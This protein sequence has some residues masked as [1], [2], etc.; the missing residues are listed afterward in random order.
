MFRC[1]IR[2][3]EGGSTRTSAQNHMIFV[4]M[5]FS[6]VTYIIEYKMYN[7]F[8]SVIYSE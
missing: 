5:L 3:L 4:T 7:V 8:Q 2:H 1:A 6:T